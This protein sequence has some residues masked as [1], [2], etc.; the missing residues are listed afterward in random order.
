MN[1]VKENMETLFRTL[2]IKDHKFGKSSY[3]IGRLVGY[4]QILCEGLDKED[5]KPPYAIGENEEGYILVCKCTPDVYA[6][7]TE[8][9]RREFPEDLCVFN[10]RDKEKE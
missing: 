7:F 1:N 4:Q 6:K 2:V 3:M 5:H 8:I 10:Y 9:V